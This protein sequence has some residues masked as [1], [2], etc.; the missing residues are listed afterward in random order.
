MPNWCENELYISGPD[1]RRVLEAIKGE[2]KDDVID[3]DK[4]IPMPDSLKLISGGG[5]MS[6]LPWRSGG[7]V[8]IAASRQFWSGRLSKET[9]SPRW[10]T[11][12]RVSCGSTVLPL[13]R[14][15]RRASTRS[16]P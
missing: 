9:E 5:G 11:C 1:V 3:F 7:A 8:T 15:S 13:P 12:R 6:P 10:T 2:N 14:L 16:V 4:I